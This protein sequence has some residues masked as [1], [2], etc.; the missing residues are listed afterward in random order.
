MVM[1]S[2]DVGVCGI[3]GT[4]IDRGNRSFFRKPYSRATLSTPDSISI[5]LGM[6]P[7]LYGK[8]PVT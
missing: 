5:T 4:L 3:R 8:N 6:H 2:D 7:V 1:V